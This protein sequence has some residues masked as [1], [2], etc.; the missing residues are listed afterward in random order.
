MP[1]RSGSKQA[2][3]RPVSELLQSRSSGLG[4][5]LNHAQYLLMLDK[6]LSCIV[7]PAIAKQVQVAA[8]N[9]R[10]LLLITPS[11]A[12]A[13][14]L[15]HDSQCLLK[16]LLASGVRGIDDIQVRTAPLS[17]AREEHRQRRAL[18]EIAKQSLQRFAQDS[19]DPE[20]LAI[21]RKRAQEKP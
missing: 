3:P 21:I 14:R 19:G 12:L 5:L 7:E 13:T 20:I 1:R 18:P 10:C 15:R 16:T 17:L 8:L 11:A 4:Q 6:K 2:K 9:Q